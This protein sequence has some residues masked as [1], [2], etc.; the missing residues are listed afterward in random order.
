MIA[1]GTLSPPRSKAA[2]FSRPR[3]AGVVGLPGSVALQGYSAI[4]RKSASC[5]VARLL[6]AKEL[7]KIFLSI[8]V[9]G[10]RTYES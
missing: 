2:R 1:V 6:T 5:W 7:A 3:L 8:K 4:G 10:S 9:S